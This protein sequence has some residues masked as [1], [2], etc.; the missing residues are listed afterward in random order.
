MWRAA[1]GFTLLEIVVVLIVMGL[2]AALVVP[3]LRPP[4]PNEPSAS[5]Q[6]VIRWVQ[7]LAV[8]RGETVLLDVSA[9]GAWTA[10]GAA[11]LEVGPLGAG[12]L[13]G[14]PPR[15]GFSLRVGPMG[16]CGLTLEADTLG[17]RPPLDPLTCRVV[18]P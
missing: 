8:R 1:S 3:A 9:Q 13:D 7:D 10:H 2:A 11:S 15:Y 6:G 14:E 16:S 12:E 4:Q 18:T 5:L 17:W